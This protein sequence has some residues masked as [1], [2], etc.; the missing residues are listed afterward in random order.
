MAQLRQ[1]SLTLV[2]LWCIFT[3]GNVHLDKMRT[4][5]IN[6]DVFAF[7]RYNRSADRKSPFSLLISLALT[8]RDLVRASS[9]TIRRNPDLFIFEEHDDATLNDVLRSAGL[10]S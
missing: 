2:F 5:V 4:S 9:G 3:E 1:S 8:V 6:L 7:P 10:F